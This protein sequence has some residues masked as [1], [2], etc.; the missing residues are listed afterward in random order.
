[1]ARI[2]M[3]WPA[4]NRRTSPP[5]IAEPFDERMMF[6]GGGRLDI[7]TPATTANSFLAVAAANPGILT[8]ANGKIRIPAGVLVVRTAVQRD[9]Y[10]APATPTT[11]ALSPTAPV[12]TSTSAANIAAANPPNVT[13]VTGWRLAIAADFDAGG[14]PTAANNIVEA[15]LT[16][17]EV[18]DAMNNPGI[19][20]LRPQTLIYINWLP[21][22]PNPYALANTGLTPSTQ[23][24][25]NLAGASLPVSGTP[26]APAIS[27]VLWPATIQ[28]AIRRIYQTTYGREVA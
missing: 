17:F 26:P 10:T 15:Y 23:Q 7:V 11:Q 19:E 9:G 27:G 18:L 24:Y 13:A 5:F 22:W 14:N 1:M 3:P 6:P 8:D 20:L 16:A 12:D 28:A 25:T 4:N 2:E 21:F